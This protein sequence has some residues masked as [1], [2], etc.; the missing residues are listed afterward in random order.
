MWV[1][2]TDH[3]SLLEHDESPATARLRERLLALNPADYATS[4]ISYEEQCRGWLEHI[5]KKKS[6]LEQVTAYRKLHKQLE[7]YGAIQ[8]LDFDEHAAIEFQRLRAAK[9][10]IKTMD[11]KIASIVL[12][13]HATLLTRNT[14]DFI[15]VPGLQFEDWT[16]ELRHP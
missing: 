12:S 6:V 2:D 1:L 15:K 16:R 4:I 3:I 7:H 13:L 5:K 11:L 9:V 14:G 10:R 8:V